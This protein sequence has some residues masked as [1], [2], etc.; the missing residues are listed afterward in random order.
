MVKKIRANSNPHLLN[1]RVSGSG[2]VLVFLHG[3]LASSEYWERTRR[4]LAKDHTVVAVDLL[5]FGK[6]PK[7]YCS[8]YDYTA[9][10]ES[11][12]MTLDTLGIKEPFVL[13]GHSMGSLIA[14]RY[15][16]TYPVAIK[17]LL[18]TNMPIML[19]PLEVESE[20][21]S[22]KIAKL[23]L[24]PLM[25]FIMWGFF[26]WTVRLRL[27]P[28]RVKQNLDE[29][30]SYVFQH[31]SVSRVRSFRSV[32]VHGT[33]EDDLRRVS[34]DTTLLSG[35]NDRKIYLSNLMKL[36]LAP[37]I[38]VQSVDSTHHIPILMP[39]LIARFLQK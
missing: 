7:P 18:L 2:P 37:N 4:L 27:L 25:Q 30:L 14:L 6:S 13:V 1:T 3:F 29:R 15:A 24:H 9:H 5:G 12:R 11:I 22:S 31:N 38:A 8:R 28:S 20:I 21:Y 32:I 33:V 16:N 35:T 39:E 10:I 34:A 23:G 17:K 36:S 19:S 26:R